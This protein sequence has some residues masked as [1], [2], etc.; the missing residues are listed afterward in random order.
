MRREPPALPNAKPQRRCVWP[1]LA[2]QATRGAELA[3]QA[4]REAETAEAL[5]KAQA[6]ERDASLAAEK[7]ANAMPAMQHARSAKKFGGAGTS[8]CH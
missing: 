8:D 1:G 4:R 5:D 7:K 6:A 3:A 2:A